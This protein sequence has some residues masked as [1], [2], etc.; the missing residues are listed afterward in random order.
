MTTYTLTFT[1]VK[2]NRVP[3]PYW[4]FVMDLSHRFNE[5][6]HELNSLESVSTLWED[7]YISRKY[8][9]MTNLFKERVK[10]C[11]LC[12]YQICSILN[13]LAIDNIVNK[14]L[15]G[16]ELF[17]KKHLNESFSCIKIS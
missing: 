3:N 17:L 11:G 16:L 1:N 4:L 8:K 7:E 9:T 6:R 12:T 5:N 14:K 13:K 15:N 2:P 10:N